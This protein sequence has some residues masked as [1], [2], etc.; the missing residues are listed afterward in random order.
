MTRTSL[1]K[2]RRE[3]LKRKGIATEPKTKRLLTQAEL[4]DLYPKTSKM[5]Y[6]ELKYKIHL[7]DVIF[8]GSL[9][10]VCGYFRWEVDRST[11]SRWRKHIEEAFYGGKL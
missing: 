8:L 2:L 3:I 5:R 4:P 6:I 7:E 9:T 11:I 1:A 10:D